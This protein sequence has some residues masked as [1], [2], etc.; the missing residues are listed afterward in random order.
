MPEGILP[1][2][3]AAA[4]TVLA[5]GV[6]AIL[7]TF[8]EDLIDLFS[9]RLFSNRDLKGNWD[10][11]WE[12]TIPDKQ[13]GYLDVVEFKGVSG[14]RIRAVGTTRNFGSYKLRGR[15]SQASLLTFYYEGAGKKSRTLGGVVILELNAVRNKLIGR[16]Y[17]YTED[18]KIIGGATE[19]TKSI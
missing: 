6:G 14:E 4:G 11:K 18:R 10:C 9:G 2:V 17:E 15:L 1:A 8:S 7:K 13:K 5:A 16:W 12:V 3:I 19:W